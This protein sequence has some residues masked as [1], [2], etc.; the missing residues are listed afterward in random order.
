MANSKLVCIAAF[1]LVL[2]LSDA[3][4]SAAGRP[5]K[6]QGNNNG[7]VT[8]YQN[9]VKEVAA[10]AGEAAPSEP[11]TTEP[12]ESQNPR[13]DD[14]V[15]KLIDDFRPTEPGHSPGAGHGQPSP[16]P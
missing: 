4:F 5:V 10:V 6:T 1:L 3:I 9:S 12:A 14:Q 13:D 8:T 2:M 15:G 16:R 11:T 7:H